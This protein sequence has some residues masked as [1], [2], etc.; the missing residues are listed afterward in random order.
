MESE[1]PGGL[2]LST[3]VSAASAGGWGAAGRTAAT[4]PEGRG[5]SAP[6]MTRPYFAR[7]LLPSV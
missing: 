2:F 7:R 6:P 4:G 3:G 1:G 5:D